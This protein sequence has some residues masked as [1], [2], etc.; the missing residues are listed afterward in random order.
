MACR[1]DRNEVRQVFA[2]CKKG[3]SALRFAQ[4]WVSVIRANEASRCEGSG[5]KRNCIIAS[6]SP[7]SLSLIS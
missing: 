4:A 2:I 3:E 7:T 6:F 5:R 1:F